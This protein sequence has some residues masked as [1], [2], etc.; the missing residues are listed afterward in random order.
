M[1]PTTTANVRVL[2]AE[3]VTAAKLG[4]KPL[5]RR[6]LR[7]LAEREP[8]NE[9]VWLWLA[10]LSEGH[11]EAFEALN[12][13][14]DINPNNQQALNA[15]ALARL[16]EGSRNHRA[17]AA[18]AKTAGPAAGGAVKVVRLPETVAAPPRPPAAQVPCL[19]CQAQMTE[20]QA[21]CPR[22]GAVVR[23]GALE[24]F[25]QNKG[26]NEDAV[27]EAIQR[28]QAELNRLETAEG[29]VSLALAYLNLNRSADAAPHLKSALRLKP[30]QPRVERLL[31]QLLSRRLI[32]A[33]DDSLT[34]RKIVSISLERLGYRVSTAADGMQALAKL[35]EETPDLIL[36]DIT[37]P[38]MDGYQ[39]CKVIK[40][41][42]YTKDIPVVM[43]SGKDGFFDKVKGKMAGATDYITKPFREITLTRAIE[44][45]LPVKS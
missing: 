35:N 33:V 3:A 36:L 4:Q 27:F 38:R 15:L 26:V 19:V 12:R 10:A 28:V 17:P 25:T 23:M 7:E 40:K 8:K 29:H 39:V 37:M 5:A 16:T 21:R 30:G 6:L 34:V 13:V 32:L 42:P 20:S 44:R 9:N 22:C 45:Y 14:L 11:Q 2:L 24:E 1:P 41:N 31:N 18:E 43:L